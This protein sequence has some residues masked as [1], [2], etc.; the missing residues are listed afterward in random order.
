MPGQASQLTAAMH[1]VAL[2]GT[3]AMQI[4]R[5]S[6]VCSCCVLPPEGASATVPVVHQQAAFDAACVKL[7][8]AAL[9]NDGKMSLLVWYWERADRNDAL[10]S[11]QQT[12]SCTILEHR[13]VCGCRAG[14]EA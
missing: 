1:H 6:Q 10:S 13:D 3:A 11:K 12:S 7:L 5:A 9:S 4:L 14:V 2:R 8:K